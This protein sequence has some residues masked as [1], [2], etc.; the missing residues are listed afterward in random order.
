MNKLQQAKLLRDLNY[1][2]A[3]DL[4]RRSL[5]TNSDKFLLDVAKKI[6]SNAKLG[7]YECE[8]DM[9]RPIMNNSGLKNT[10]VNYFKKI[11]FKVNLK[12]SGE[13]HVIWK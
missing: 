10:I 8:L 1:K 4:T 5:S 11:G 13:F 6:I 12:G 7:Q 3:K 2:Y 9:P